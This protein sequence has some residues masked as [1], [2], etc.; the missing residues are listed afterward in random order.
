[1]VHL[2]IAQATANPFNS[3]PPW[4]DEGLATYYQEVKDPRFDRVLNSAVQGGTLIPLRALNAGFPDDPNLALLSYAESESVVQF[5]IEQ[6]GQD[7]MAALINVFRDGVSYDQAVQKSLGIS[8]DELDREWKAWLG[9]QGDKPTTAHKPSSPGN[10]NPA[11]RLPDLLTHL[12]A[13]TYAAI[14]LLCLVSGAVI[15]TRFVAAR[16]E[17]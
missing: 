16:R 12:D 4:L 1:V 3:P 13:L 8:L 5:I 10:G 6:K 17:E 15:V 14:A 7:R 2:I 11:E 9:Y